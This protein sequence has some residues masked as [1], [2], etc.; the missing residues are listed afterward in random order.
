MKSLST[1]AALL[2]VALTAGAQ[3]NPISWEFSTRKISNTEYDLVFVATAQEGWTLYS[4]FTEEGG[5]V[6]TEFTFADESTYERKGGVQEQTK[7]KTGMDPLFGVNVSKFKKSPVEFTQRITVEQGTTVDGYV[8][9][10]T[11]D[12]GRCLPPKDVDFSFDIPEP[13]VTETVTAVEPVTP[14]EPTEPTVATPTTS[15]TT[16]TLAPEPTNPRTATSS[17][18][19]ANHR[20]NT[21]TAEPEPETKSEVET[22]EAETEAPAEQPS[23]VETGGDVV[24]TASAP[25]VEWTF[26]QEELGNNEYIFTWRAEAEEGWTV[27]S[28]YTP[29]GGPVPTEFV[30]SDTNNV[31]L[32]G[33]IV[34]RGK[35]KRAMDPLFGV[36]VVKFPEGTVDFVQRVRILDPAQPVEGYLT[37]MTCDDATCLPPKD[38]DFAFL[39]PDTDL[40][41]GF[42]VPTEDKNFRSVFVSRRDGIESDNAVGECGSPVETPTGWWKIFLLGFGGGLLALLTPCVFPML[43]LTVSFFTHRSKTRAQGIRNAITYALSIIVLY[44][45]MGVGLTMLFGPEVLNKMSTNPWFN[46]AFFAIFVVF[47][48]SFFGLF[49]ITLP[50]SWVNKS[51]AMADKGGLLGIF[52]MAFTLAL[53]SFSCTGPIIGTLLVETAMGSSTAIGGVVPLEPLLGML[54]FSTALALPF[55]LFAAFPAW[56][57]SLPKSGGWMQDV[58]VTLGF[59]ELALA[60]KFFS[61]ADM[62]QH[63]GVLKFEPF[64]L[65]WA[66]CFLGLGLY[67]FGILKFKRPPSMRKVGTGRALF[68][69]ASLL[70]A[71]YL[72]YGLVTYT[73]LSAMSGLAPPVHYSFF[74]PNDCPHGLDCYKDFDDAVASAKAQDKPIFVDFTGYGCVN[75]RYVEE[76]IWV[77]SEVL[78]H[79]RDNYV[80]VSLYVD[81]GA[82]LYPEDKMAYDFDPATNTKL[83]TVGSKWAA[84]EINNFGASTQPLYVTMHHDGET[85][86]TPPAGFPQVNTVERYTQMLECGLNAFERVNGQNEQ[87]GSR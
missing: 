84:F 41:S 20:T 22:A 69:A 74:N 27:Y 87:L 57:N 16:T 65:I 2:L 1:L 9:Y 47:A 19:A 75:C 39:T 76:N 68:G 78:A 14:V 73:S 49:E 13:V 59:V 33:E 10:M 53:V 71:G 60:F 6:P 64:M 80:V 61:V 72:T 34:E 15:T 54:G 86:L 4:Q 7:V 43:P 81:D 38:I 31:Q 55:A 37:F 42:A 30:F 48:L 45:T 24:G 35:E 51:D 21:S 28:S 25:R 70:F 67:M 82:R 46:M 3:L 32:I 44:C 26:I 36:E 85:V 66:L 29:E 56:L 18:A 8:T 12:D 83:R 11:C 77:D 63:W 50:S 62:V 40:T 52:F 17:T 79:L 58:K 5:P 23:V